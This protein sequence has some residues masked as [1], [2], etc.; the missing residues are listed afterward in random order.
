MS[1]KRHAKKNQRQNEKRYAR[2][3]AVRSATAPPS[4][5]STPRAAPGA[6]PDVLKGALTKEGY[7]AL[8]VA[9]RKGV[10][11]GARSLTKSRLANDKRR[12]GAP[13]AGRLSPY[14]LKNSSLREG[15]FFIDRARAGL[16]TAPV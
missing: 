14:P 9:G 11:T 1:A 5:R 10:L 2:N 4:K 3:K 6:A 13:N 16:R 15:G 8:D 7:R 12:R